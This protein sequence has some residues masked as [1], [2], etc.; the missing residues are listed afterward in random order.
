M[1]W[2]FC[3]FGRWGRLVLLTGSLGVS[4]CGSVRSFVKPTMDK[5]ISYSAR[6]KW[7]WKLRRFV[8][9]EFPHSDK[10]LGKDWGDIEWARVIWL[11]P[12]SMELFKNL[13]PAH[14]CQG[15]LLALLVRFVWVQLIIMC[16]CYGFNWFCC[17]MA[18]PRM[19]NP[20]GRSWYTKQFISYCWAQHLNF[21]TLAALQAQLSIFAG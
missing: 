2:P 4:V 9:P 15:P 8:D 1:C 12:S 14:V 3:L 20:K 19:V 13:E 17:L 7:G 11:G 21:S 6:N 18:P 10:S 5:Q 16:R